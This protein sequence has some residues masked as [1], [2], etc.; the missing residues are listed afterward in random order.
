MTS[1]ARRARNAAGSAPAPTTSAAAR[2]AQARSSSVQIARAVRGLHG[3]HRDDLEGRR[4]V[5]VHL[6]ASAP[7]ASAAAAAAQRYQTARLPPGAGPRSA[8]QHGP[9]LPSSRTGTRGSIHSPKND[10]AFRHPRPIEAIGTSYL[11][12]PAVE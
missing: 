11:M 2:L 7:V 5:D 12:D 3:P 8:A 9:P 1:L 6:P 4:F 10:Y